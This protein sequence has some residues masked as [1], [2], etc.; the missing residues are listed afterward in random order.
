[1]RIGSLRFRRFSIIV[2]AGLIGCASLAGKSSQPL[3]VDPSVHILLKNDRP[4]PS[5]GTFK[6]DTK[7]FKVNYTKD[8]DLDAVDARI[9][10]SL[11]S[12][13]EGKGFLRSSGR[14]DLLVSYGVALDSPISGADL[15]EAYP[16]ELPI[17]SPQLEADEQLTYHHGTLIV[18]FVD[19]ESREL[20][21]RG[22]VMAGLSME[23]SDEE[24][25]R[26]VAEAVRIL[27]SHFPRPTA[28]TP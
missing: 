7:L 6:F 24:K 27:L 23:V 17:V 8:F 13:L 2:V 1:M 3:L 11:E 22:A 19:S 25:D 12:E 5:S 10:R 18:D 16:D 20:L 4:V 21:W 15:N 9:L 28:A 26:R 14:P